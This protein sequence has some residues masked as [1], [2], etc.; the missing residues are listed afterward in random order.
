MKNGQKSTI[1][2]FRLECGHPFLLS[3]NA[4][5]T[6]ICDLNLDVS[7]SPT[8]LPHL[9]PILVFFFS[10]IPNFIS[11]SE[12]FNLFLPFMFHF[13]VYFLHFSHF[14]YFSYFNLLL[15]VHFID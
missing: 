7:N 8:L 10:F 9:N 3:Q 11:V 4:Y 13:F 14:L 2:L 6:G 12:G 1:F 5:I 15:L